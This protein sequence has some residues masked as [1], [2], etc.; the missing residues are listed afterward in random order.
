MQRLHTVRM[1]TPR[2]I[3][4]DLDGTL[5]DTRRDI[6][7]SV[8]HTLRLAGRP[9]L[10]ETT[11][12]SFVGDGARTLLSRVM[13][14]PENSPELSTHLEVFLEHY[15]SNP[16]QASTWMPD[17]QAC[18][19][20]FSHIPRALVT[21]KPRRVTIKILEHLNLFGDFDFLY[22]G[23]DG[24]AKPDPEPLSRACARWGIAA[25]HLWMVGDGDQDVIAAHR[26]GATAI[27]VLGGF[28]GAER[29]RAA[30]PTA[31]VPSLGAV[32]QLSKDLTVPPSRDEPRSP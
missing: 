17:A 3:A 23:G 22:C 32:C 8:L 5:L 26:A 20:F 2:A 13:Q 19:Q 21:N 7:A 10:P 29:L 18:L 31:L 24:P 25:E 6:A 12:A 14:L 30:Q 16:L 27:A 9:G 11:I 28:Q 4:F 1:Q 15:E